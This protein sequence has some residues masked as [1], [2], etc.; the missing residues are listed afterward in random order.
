MQP[1]RV[2][3]AGRFRLTPRPPETAAIDSRGRAVSVACEIAAKAVLPE[4]DNNY[5]A[6]DNSQWG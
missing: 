5:R 2:P 1:G 4:H 6:G 3:A